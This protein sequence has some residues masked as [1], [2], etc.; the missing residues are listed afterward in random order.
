MVTTQQLPPGIHPG[1]GMREY[2]AWSLD[3]SKLIEGPIS[4][5]TLCDF[6]PNPYA[7]VRTEKAVTKAM[8]TGSLFDLAL[9][10]DAAMED[11][12]AINPYSDFKTKAAQD[13]RDEQICYGKLIVT[14]EGLAHARKAAAAVRSHHIAGGILSGCAFQ[15]AVVGEIQ[16]IP[17]KCLI[18]ILPSSGSEW[19]ETIVDYKTTTSGIDD[20]S[21]RKTIGKFKYH[22]RAAFYRTLFNKV[23]RNRHCEDWVFIF[24]D[25]ETLEVRCVK[26]HQ[27]DLGLG[28]RMIKAA[29][30]EFVRCAKKGVGSRYARSMS[31]LGVMPYASIAESEWLDAIETPPPSER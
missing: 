8:S 7:W 22:W 19:A 26:L 3:K 5:S 29:V 21:I 28:T 1:L 27:D 11:S 16:G 12:V 18:D 9:T 6:M 17:A 24:Q 15:T 20:D 25:Q 30:E 23:S 10:D 4:A 14:E 31:E 13:W 2:H